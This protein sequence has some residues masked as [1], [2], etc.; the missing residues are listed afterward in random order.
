MGLEDT[1]RHKG[2]RNQ[3]VQ[4]IR[5]KGIEDERILTVIQTLPR[6]WFLDTAFLEH[7]YQDKAFA[8][9]E[10][11]TISQPFTV[12]FQTQLLALQKYDKIL[13]IGT[14]SGYQACIL[15]MLG[16]K[17]YSIEYNEVLHQK[18]QKLIQQVNLGGM[19]KLFQGDGSRGLP[20][21]APFQGII[22]TAGA[23]TV[24]NALLKQL[25]AGGRLVIPVG[26][27][28]VQTMMRITRKGETTFEQEAFEQF[29]FVPLLG[30]HGWKN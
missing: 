28:K 22:V 24:P 16:A 13:E 21:Y 11:Q 9:G 29:K 27:E 10:G 20:A 15:A 1:Y 18:A 26:D 17:V 14:G 7:A 8:I 25:K 6:H 30:K 5:R 3:L 23:P 19:T 12:A 2:L 4:L